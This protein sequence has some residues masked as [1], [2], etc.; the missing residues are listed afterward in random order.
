MLEPLTIPIPNLNNFL[1]DGADE[2]GFDE[3]WRT[4]PTRKNSSKSDAR[5]AY[6]AALKKGAKP[7][8]ILAGAELY[9]ADRAG[10][11]PQYTAHAKTW[12]NGK[13]WED[14][15][16]KPALPAPKRKFAWEN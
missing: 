15:I 6:R 4:Y 13:R 7:D 11:D 3:F 10:Q 2:T 5:T 12:L 14:A 8:E 16:A 9:A 1:S